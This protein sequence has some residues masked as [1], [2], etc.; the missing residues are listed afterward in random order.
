V[1][2][3]TLKKEVQ[4]KGRKLG[5]I[6]GYAAGE[7]EF[8]NRGQEPLGPK[9]RAQKALWHY[10]EEGSEEKG[11]KNMDAC[12]YRLRAPVEFGRGG[13]CTTMA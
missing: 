8:E 10:R 1:D 5:K 2:E 12:V 13:Y 4:N 6:C 11:G 9:N 7:G 3:G